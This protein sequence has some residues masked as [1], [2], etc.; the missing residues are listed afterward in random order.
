MSRS[1]ARILLVLVLFSALPIPSNA[2]SSQER[3]YER[4]FIVDSISWLWER[5]STP[6]VQL[7]EGK[8]GSDT[9][10]VTPPPATTDGRGA[11]DPNG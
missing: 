10:G 7:L 6:W 9:A 2:Q 5:I 11:L 4:H 8:T 1:V 3:N